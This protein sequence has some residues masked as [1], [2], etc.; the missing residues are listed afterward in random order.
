MHCRAKNTSAA[1]AGKRSAVR[2][3][4]ISGLC[5]VPLSIRQRTTLDF[6]CLTAFWEMPV[7]VRKNKAALDRIP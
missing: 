5:N 7:H 1:C 6:G 2:E 3:H 4:F